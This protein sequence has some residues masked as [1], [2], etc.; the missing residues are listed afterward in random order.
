MRRSLAAILV[1]TLSSVASAQSPDPGVPATDAARLFEEGR[2]LAKDGKYTEACA[3]FTKSYELDRG[4]G[5]ELNLADCDEHLG[6]YADAWRLFDDAALQ[7]A[8]N[9]PRAKFA[10]ERATALG[11]KVATI[12]VKIPDPTG[13]TV[14]IGG[15]PVTAAAEIRWRVDPGTI[16]VV[17]TA[18]GRPVFKKSQD[19]IGG[20]IVTVN[21]PGEA[22]KRVDVQPTERHEEPSHP[23]EPP[24]APTHDQRD[25]TRVKIAALLGGVGVA[26]MIVSFSFALTGRSQYNAAFSSGSC[27]KTSSALVCDNNGYVKAQHAG[28]LANIGTVFGVASLALVGAGAYVFITAPHETVVA[29]AVTT[30]SVGI[31]V[32]GRF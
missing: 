5:T 16:E 2:V 7:S 20:E 26:S 6:H 32:A 3:S 23:P 4:V 31:T 14:T 28:T 11:P 12:V 1:V 29:P 30:D 22:P 10:R 15:R 27:V 18:P 9:P 17:V 13:A 21:V 24:F 19:T 25:P 8:S